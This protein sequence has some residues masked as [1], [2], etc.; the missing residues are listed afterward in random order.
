MLTRAD[1][2]STDIAALMADMG[3]RARA[4]SAP[5]STA[6]PEAKNA[7]LAAMADAIVAGMD[8]ILAANALDMEKAETSGLSPAFKDRLKL[9]GDRVGA[10]ADGIRAIAE[11]TDPVGAVID[12]VGAAERPEDRPRAHAAR[13]HRRDLRVP[14]Q[15]HRRRRR[16]LCVKAGNAVIL[17]G[18]SE[19]LNSSPSAIHACLAPTIAGGRRTARRR[20][21]SSCRPATGRRSAMMLTMLGAPS[22]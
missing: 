9:D 15:R 22:T 1:S 19:S 18:G 17:R 20:R 14:A 11:L 8:T 3:A 21:S 13:G 5:L 10:M 6:K 16:A 2:N 12:T 4:A 7:A